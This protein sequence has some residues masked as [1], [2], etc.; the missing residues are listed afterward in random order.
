MP[1]GW[2]A[3][4][5]L[6]GKGPSPSCPPPAAVGSWSSSVGA[7]LVMGLQLPRDQRIRSGQKVYTAADQVLGA[8]HGGGG[9]GGAH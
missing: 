7:V 1:W 6:S 5:H 4:G 9:Q 2:R 8:W 3:M